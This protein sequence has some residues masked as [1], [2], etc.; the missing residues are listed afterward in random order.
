PRILNAYIA[1]TEDDPTDWLILGYKDTRDTISLYACGENGLSEFRDNL[2][3]EILFGFVRVEDKF[4]LIT[5]VPDSVSGV[6][7]ARALV[8]S[9]AVANILELSHAQLT[10]S[11][12]TDLSDANIRTRLKLN[13]NQV[14]NRRAVS[15]RTSMIT[16]RRKSG[17]YSPSPSPSP[18]SERNLR[19]HINSMDDY[20]DISDRMTATPTPSTPT[21]VASSSIDSH[22]FAVADSVPSFVSTDEQERKR[23]QEQTE[24]M[25]QIQLA[26]KKELEEARFRQF[27]RE[28]QEEKIRREQTQVLVV[29]ETLAV[30]DE[31]TLAAEQVDTVE[32]PLV[33]AQQ[34]P[35][36]IEQ[37]LIE[38][39]QP[40]IK[41]EQ[42]AMKVKEESPIA[43]P[44][45]NQAPALTEQQ[46]SDQDDEAPIMTGFISVQTS[47]SPFWRRRYFVLSQKACLLYKDETNKDTIH[48]IY[49]G[50]VN[51]VAPADEDED[52]YV[53]NSYMIDTQQGISFQLLADDK[54]MGKQIYTTL[55]QLC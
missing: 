21:S 7:R 9:R 29:Q 18:M 53:A 22:Y 54:K 35:A 4:V 34:P 38:D 36:V 11:N 5:Y 1:I 40:T 52:T 23:I 16:R 27:Q 14:P 12:L 49:Y 28:Q 41:A 30:P 45:V 47:T 43:Q 20:D 50:Q 39:T 6:R 55:K 3:N 8:H 10:A 2:T 51:R 33:E 15:K 48:T 37:P 13:Q 42:P 31:T 17:T 24:T 25:L 44:I 32:Q 26:K 46:S 19:I